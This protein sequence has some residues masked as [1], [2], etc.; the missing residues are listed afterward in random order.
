[1]I[2]KQSE[3]I[4]KTEWILSSSTV[5]A[6]YDPYANDVTIPTAIIM[7]PFYSKAATYAENLGGIGYVAAH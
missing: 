1:M 6:C 7:K 4:D 2:K 5:N 3:P